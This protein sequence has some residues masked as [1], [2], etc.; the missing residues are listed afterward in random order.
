MSKPSRNQFTRLTMI[1]L[2][3]QRWSW[4]LPGWV[5]SAVRRLFGRTRPASDG[6]RLVDDWSEPLVVRGSALPDTP[7]VEMPAASEALP[8]GANSTYEQLPT[9]YRSRLRCLIVTRVLDAGGIDEFVAFLARRLPAFGFYT[10]VM[11]TDPLCRKGAADRGRLAVALRSEGIMVIDVLP[12]EGRQWLAANRPDVISAHVPVQWVLEAARAL[13]IPVVETLHAVPTPIG[14]DWRKEVLRGRYITSLVAVSELVRRQYLR[15]NPGFPEEA[16]LTIPNSFND[17]HRPA[18]SRMK[19][20]AWL[21]LEEEFLFI[22]LARHVLQKNAYGLV[23]AFSDVARAVPQAHLLIAGRVDDHQYTK[24][25]RLIR[26]R[27]TGGD[28]IHLRENFLNPSALLAAA[29]GFVLNSFFEGWPLATMEALCAGLPVVMSE[30]GGAWEQVGINGERGYVVANPLGDSEVASWEKA[31][32][33]R[34]RPQVNKNELVAAMTSVIR[35]RKHWANARPVLSEESKRRF[36]AR[37]CAEQHAKVLR[38]ATKR[39]SPT[40]VAETSFSTGALVNGAVQAGD[41]L[42]D[43]FAPAGGIESTREGDEAALAFGTELRVC[44]ETS[45]WVA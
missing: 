11:Y 36:S 1:T 41:R 44:P 33:A 9:D 31:G 6:L 22:S 35:H 19:A 43:T 16:I 4:V 30:V 21:G 3:M 12:E 17:T 8:H 7:I 29:D 25:V 28:R 26:D 2:W 18:I 32:R 40:S 27:V 20:R 38:R 10:T 42:A 24:Q 13:S 34:F 37:T 15:G 23:T 5:R 14:T 45:S 39:S